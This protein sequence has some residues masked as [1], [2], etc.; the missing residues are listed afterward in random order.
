M[1]EPSWIVKFHT[2]PSSISTSRATLGCS[3]PV[4]LRITMCYWMRTISRL[5]V[6][7][8]SHLR[9]VMC[10]QDLRVPFPFRL[11]FT[12]CFIL[13]YILA[14]CM[15][16]TRFTIDADIVCSRAKNHYEPGG[17]L[18]I[19]FETPTGSGEDRGPTIAQ[20]KSGYKPLHPTTAT[21][22]VS[23]TPFHACYSLTVCL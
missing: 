2:L 16:L 14:I 23:L 18:D 15:P 4:V 7:S 3:G 12:V 5:T 22:M 10:M 20:Y 17:K 19:E 6:C 11:L 1:P 8:S 13:L 9:S 21:S